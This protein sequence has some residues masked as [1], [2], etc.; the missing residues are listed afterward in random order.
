MAAFWVP[1]IW[2]LVAIVLLGLELAQPSF[3]GLMFGALAALVVSVVTALGPLPALMQIG[4]FV[5]IT[6]AG[7]VW[8]TRWSSQRNPEPGDP[9]QREDLA[10]VLVASVPGGKVACAGMVK[11]GLPALSISIGL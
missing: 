7:T 8:L 5:V 1:L 11:A 3:D 10:E 2:L 6:V 4:I 9:R